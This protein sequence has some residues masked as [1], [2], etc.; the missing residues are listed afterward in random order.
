M[1]GFNH[2]TYTDRIE[3]QAYLKAGVSKAEIARKLNKHRNTINNEYKRGL[4]EQMTSELV[5]HMVYSAEYAQRDY[6]EKAK[7][8]GPALKIGNDYD[9]VEFV[10]YMIG[11][12]KFSPDAVTG[13]IKTHGM[14]FKGLVSTRT[15]YNYIDSGDIFTNITRESLWA[16]NKKKRKYDKL[17]RVR[18]KKPLLRSIDVRPPEVNERHEAGHWEMDLVEGKRGGSG[19]FLLVLTERQSRDHLIQKIPDKKQE[20]VRR[21]LDGIECR[22]GAEKF[23]KVFKSI[24]MDNGSEFL[25]DTFIESSVFGGVRTSAY[26]C[27]PYSSFERGSNENGNR[28]I[29]RFIPKGSDIDDYTDDDIADI[30]DWINRYP[31]RLLDYHSSREL[32]EAAY[33][34]VV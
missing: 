33:G 13:Y 2:L 34:F 16:K 19:K 22:L 5:V 18:T 15:L 7:A 27:H 11:K 28:M 12:K 9:Y 32:F 23:K 29:R 6:D 26:Y 30:Q 20:S 31:R 21:A 3:M 4:C 14:Q 8:K 17:K 25:N 10:E 1:Q 24:T